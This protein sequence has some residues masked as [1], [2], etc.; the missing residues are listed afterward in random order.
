MTPEE[1]R[2]FILDGAGKPFVAGAPLISCAAN[3]VVQG[4]VKSAAQ[5]HRPYLEAELAEAAAPRS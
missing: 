2:R 3:L 4:G 1:I 5:P